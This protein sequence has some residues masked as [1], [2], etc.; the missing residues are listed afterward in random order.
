[1]VQ[2]S[3]YKVKDEVYDKLFDLLFEIVGKRKDKKDFF[4]II[5]D[6]FS[7]QERLMIA[8]RTAII[9]LLLQ[10]IDY[11]IICDV[12]KVS[13]A[14]VAKFAIMLEK[15]RALHE[16]FSPLITNKKIGLFF[17]E[18]F[19]TFV[20]PGTFGTNESSAWKHKNSIERR[21]L[22]GL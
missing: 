13:T 16:V 11:V 5:T 6:I 21:K 2:M 10:H 3:K 8:K 18:M 12:L 14:T 7:Q 17:E 19:R 4:N 9:Y 1:M 15:S 20:P 22:Q